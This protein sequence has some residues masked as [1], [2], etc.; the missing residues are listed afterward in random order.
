MMIPTA[1]FFSP[2]AARARTRA[3][4]WVLVGG[5]G[6][7]AG[8]L[9]S[10]RAPEI[11]DEPVAVELRELPPGVGDAYR[12][13]TS[14]SLGLAERTAA[15]TRL[16]EIEDFSADRALAAALG[17]AQPEVAWRAV[18][19]AVA[20]DPA[21]PPRGL[22]RPM[23]PMLY[24]VDDSIV[25]DVVMA[26]GRYADAQLVQRL[27]ATA[28]SPTLPARERARAVLALS[29]QRTQPTADLLVALTSFTEPTEVQSAAYTALARLSGIDAYGENRLAWTVWWDDA[30]ELD[31]LN[32]QRMLVDNFARKLAVGR[33]TD[34]QLAEK[35][36]QAERALYQ[37]SASADQAGV[38]AY[39]LDSPLVATRLLAL[40]LAQTR[41]VQGVEF[42]EPLRAALRAR[43]DDED[44]AEV[45]WLSAEVLRD[46]ADEP[47]ADAVAA[48]LNANAEHVSRVKSAYLQL[49]A[50]MPRKDVTNT[51]YDLMEE[52][53][54]RADACA[55]LA[56]ISKA[57]MLAPKRAEAV[58]ERLRG[59][60]REGQRPSPAMIRLLGLIGQNDEWRRIAGWIDDPEDVV[61]QAAAQAWADS[62][63]SLAILAERAD[64][65]II[66]PIVLRAATQ[67]QRV[68]D[69]ETLRKLASNP[70]KQ[71]Q[72]VPAWERAL[73]A[74][75]GQVPARD[76]LV[77]AQRLATDRKDHELV[78]SFLTAAVDAAI[79]RGD[80]EAA[81]TAS[82]FEL[83]LERAENRLAMD[84]PDL[85]IIDYEF[86]LDQGP[87]ALSNPQRNELY[88]G[89]IPAYLQANRIEQAFTT[90]RA[91]FADPAQPGRI[92]PAATDD[93]LMGNFIRAGHRAADLGRVENARQIGDGLRLL[94]GPNSEGRIKPELA[95]QLRLLDEK[96]AADRNASTA[97]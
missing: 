51:A 41:M 90:A 8:V 62:A 20:T 43:L 26:M 87:A 91:F 92:D 61:R 9:P 3:A 14:S 58:L 57:N 81:A 94:L 75:A 40:D 73:V 63:R 49:L 44:S 59:Y 16:L 60:V 74:M 95:Q 2:A 93:P 79:R 37:A 84:D 11:G 71:P 67:P 27:R 31:P 36:W 77:T 85:A 89:L 6:L 32:W 47:A 23:L 7:A 15:A 88:R 72:V 39:M 35:L 64:D 96:L 68:Q 65:P 10:C 86:L 34:Q 54:L 55:A 76:A 13:L 19:Q 12:E 46:L 70:P 1:K 83:R 97:P 28:T 17:R 25:P 18:L 30:R 33:A 82:Y 45:R 78:E 50:R 21:V 24:A 80:D 22:W 66:Q 5:L 56:S 69:P 42:E 38:L 48:R 53:G 52:P 4:W 29:E